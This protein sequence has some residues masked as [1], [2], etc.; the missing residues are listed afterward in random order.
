MD[1]LLRELGQILGDARDRLASGSVDAALASWNRANFIFLGAS[2]RQLQVLASPLGHPDGMAPTD[3]EAFVAK[4]SSLS[5]SLQEAEA[6]W[7]SEDQGSALTAYRR[8]RQAFLLIQI[9]V[10]AHRID[11]LTNEAT[12]PSFVPN[13]LWQEH[14]GQTDIDQAL[15]RVKATLQAA[16]SPGEQLI[17]YR[18]ARDNSWRPNTNG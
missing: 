12:R 7:N 4:D 8:A 1:G 13:Q 16:G 10:L 15:K 6:D 5:Q 14:A 2:I 9:A 3:W 17:A 18:S 11:T